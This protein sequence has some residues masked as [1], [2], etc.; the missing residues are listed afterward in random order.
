ATVLQA[1]G[2]D[3]LDPATGLVY[4]APLDDPKHAHA[5]A[6]HLGRAPV[7]HPNPHDRHVGPHDERRG[8]RRPPPQARARRSRGAVLARL[9]LVARAHPHRLVVPVAARLARRASPARP[10]PER[11]AAGPVRRRVRH[12]HGDSARRAAPALPPRSQD[13][14]RA[15]PLGARLLLAGP[16]RQTRRVGPPLLL[17]VVVSGLGSTGVIWARDAVRVKDGRWKERAVVV[18]ADGW[19]GRV[20][21]TVDDAEAW[22]A[23]WTQA[24]GQAHC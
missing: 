16:A 7:P 17:A 15:H 5:L 2:G 24:T 10:G 23:A 9:A 4:H 12:P 11:A 19:L 14:A 6:A 20:G 1:S 3:G 8:Q 13:T 22:W 18:D 21:F